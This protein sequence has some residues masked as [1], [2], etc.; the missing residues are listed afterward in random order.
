M[1]DLDRRQLAAALAG[2]TFI[3]GLPVRADDKAKVP[4]A[5]EALLDLLV[6]RCGKHFDD[7]D[8]AAL[9]QRLRFSESGVLARTLKL[10]WQDEPAFVYSPDTD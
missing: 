10:D 8:R 2:L 1:P 4:T 7:A 6:A 9:G 3:G 5:G